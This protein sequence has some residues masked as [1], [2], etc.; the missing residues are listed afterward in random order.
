MKMKF[1]LLAAL[2]V[3]LPSA[4]TAQD[5][6]KESDAVRQVV[7][8]Y[9]GGANLEAKRGA[10]HP[11]A[12]ILSVAGRIGKFR[13]VETPVSKP[14]KAIPG[15]TIIEPSQRIVAVD[16]AE[17][18]AMVKVE[19]AFPSDLP[20]GALQNHFQYLSLLKVNGEWKIVGILMP[21]TRRVEAASK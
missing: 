2:S 7:Q 19:S 12:K 14:S 4:A 21:S 6:D 18:G 5:A 17:D 20:G 10:L 3:V 11:E 13:V 9:I 1:L 8:A 16:V 15:E